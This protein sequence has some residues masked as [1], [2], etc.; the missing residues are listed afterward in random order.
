MN[1]IKFFSALGIANLTIMLFLGGVARADRMQLFEDKMNDKE[2]ELRD[3]G[4]NAIDNFNKDMSKVFENRPVFY[5]H[6]MDSQGKEKNVEDVNNLSRNI[7]IDSIKAGQ[8]QFV[9][10]Q[11]VFKG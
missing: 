1:L 11:F 2:R 8:K 5:I 3:G 10:T 7:A 9:F 6:D 4:D